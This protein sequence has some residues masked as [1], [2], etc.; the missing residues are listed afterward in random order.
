MIGAAILA[1][2]RKLAAPL[3]AVLVGVLL[4]LMTYQWVKTSN[5]ID[6]LTERADSL[7]R[8]RADA[9]QRLVDARRKGEEEFETERQRNIAQEQAWADSYKRAE[10]I[11]KNEIADIKKSLADA[12]V[13]RDRVYDT[14]RAT[15]RALAS[16]QSSGSNLVCRSD[17]AAAALGELLIRS[18][19]VSESLGRKAEG[20]ASQVRALQ[21]EVQALEGASKTVLNP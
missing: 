21:A 8:R 13:Q 19:R 10:E 12:A 2:L 17:D 5:T 4:G 16:A 20:L 6:V 7:E 3:L 11:R 14:T 15:Y 9:V 18:D 1:L